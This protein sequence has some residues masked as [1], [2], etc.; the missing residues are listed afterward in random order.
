MYT[1]RERKNGRRIQVNEESSIPNGN[2]PAGRSKNSS[3]SN[4]WTLCSNVTAANSLRNSL[5]ITA[6]YAIFRILGS[7]HSFEW[8]FVGV[9]R[10]LINLTKKSGWEKWRMKTNYFIDVLSIKVTWEWSRSRAWTSL[11][12]NARVRPRKKSRIRF[13]LLGRSRRKFVRLFNLLGMK[14]WQLNMRSK[15]EGKENKKIHAEPFVDVWWICR[16]TRSS[17][18]FSSK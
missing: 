2:L 4:C 13:R 17:S 7:F 9:S 8:T 3:S 14:L 10:M 18:S 11:C 1:L 5:K 16:K 12:S 6:Q 15:G